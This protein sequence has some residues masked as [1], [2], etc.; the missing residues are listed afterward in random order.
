MLKPI[1]FIRETFL[2]YKVRITGLVLVAVIFWH[3]YWT[4]SVSD[5]SHLLVLTT[6][7]IALALIYLHYF[8][9]VVNSWSH[10]KYV[11]NRVESGQEPMVAVLIPTYGEPIKMVIKT[12]GSVISQN[13]SK[14]K[15][16]IVVGDDKHDKS[17]EKA[18]TEFREENKISLI[19]HE[20]PLKNS[21]LRQGEAKA[22]NLNSCLE[23]IKLNYPE[24]QYIETRDADDLVGSSDFLKHCVG[25]LQ[26]DST[27][28]F[29][30]TIKKAYTP[31]GDPFSSQETTFYERVMMERSATNS[32]FP[33][34]SGLVWRLSELNKI[35]SF[36]AW[37]LVEDLTS[38]YEILKKGGKGIYIPIIGA[39][40][41]IAPED[42]PNLYKQRGTW[43]LD[44]LRLFFWRNPFLTRGL[45]FRQRLEFFELE[46]SYILS[47]SMFLFIVNLFISLV[48]NEY[49]IR[50]D[51]FQ[52]LLHMSVFSIASEMFSIARAGHVKY[53]AQWRTRQIWM[54]LMFVFMLAIFQSLFYG[55]NRKP[56]YK[57]TRKNQLINWYWMETLPQFIIVAGLIFGIIYS[58]SFKDNFNPNDIVSIAWS[59]IYVYGLSQIVRISWFGFSFTEMFNRLFIKLVPVSV[60]N[61]IKLIAKI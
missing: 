51:T 18:V 32:V 37:N 58:L 56:L 38:G 10:S 45:N 47:I 4:W 7:S 25:T 57:V 24:I 2:K 36:P 21:P 23:F 33:C 59:L 48:F 52:F 12:L 55:P 34:G 14:D 46:F 11:E 19:Y 50:S 28:S 13:W 3:S 1:V 53:G 5:S 43:A 42:I 9:A 16:L 40:G 6:F 20:P 8:V 60:Y 31:K 17:L 49:P 35:G 15:L 27:L 29:V 39:V 26:N 61:S 22:G 44:T 54:G 41:Q 30:Q